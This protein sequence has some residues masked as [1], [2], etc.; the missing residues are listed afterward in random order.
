M[1]VSNCVLSQNSFNGFALAT[2]EAL[3]LPHRNERSKGDRITGAPGKTVEEERVAEGSVVRAWQ[4]VSQ[5][6]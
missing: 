1:A 3:L 6:G 5:A 2:G 4:F